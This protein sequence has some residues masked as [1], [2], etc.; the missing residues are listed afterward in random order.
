MVDATKLPSTYLRVLLYLE[1]N[2]FAKNK[3]RTV[4]YHFPEE[5]VASISFFVF[6]DAENSVSSEARG[7]HVQPT[8]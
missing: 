6:L 3:I 8:G 4:S 2:S 5:F 7:E 1:M